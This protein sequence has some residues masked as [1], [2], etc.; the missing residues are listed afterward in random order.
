MSKADELSNNLREQE[1]KE[2]M[3][4]DGNPNGT[5]DYSLE[6][7][8][9]RGN[10]F[11]DY[12]PSI[13]FQNKYW[14]DYK[15]DIMNRYGG[16]K[17][18][19]TIKLSEIEAFEDAS[20][21]L[22][23]VL[24]A[25]GMNLQ[26][27]IKTNAFYYNKSGR[28]PLTEPPQV[29]KTYIFFTRPDLN[30]SKANIDSH[31]TFKWLW[32]REMG[33][34]IFSMLTGPD[35]R[36]YGDITGMSP[37]E[38]GDNDELMETNPLAAAVAVLKVPTKPLAG[39]MKKFYEKFSNT[40]SRISDFYDAKIAPIYK[41]P[42][43]KPEEAMRGLENDLIK[44]LASS[45]LDTEITAQ[46]RGNPP[47]GEEPLLENIAPEKSE[48]NG[49]LA[50]ELP[51][52]FNPWTRTYGNVRTDPVT[53]EDRKMLFTSPW[54]PL[55][56]N[57]CTSAPAGKDLMLN[58]FEYA[59]DYRGHKLNVATGS[60]S[61]NNSGEESYTFKDNRL[62]YVRWLF[63]VWTQY[64]WAVNEGRMIPRWENI[65]NRTLD[66]TCG[67]YKFVLD[68]DGQTILA[69]AQYT[70]CSPRSFPMNMIFHQDK[71]LD[72]ESFRNISI[73]FAYNIYEP[74]NPETFTAFNF[75]SETEWRRKRN[76]KEDLF[77]IENTEKVLKRKLT[78][79]DIWEELRTRADQYSGVSGQVPIRALPN[80]MDTGYFNH[81]NK[82]RSENRWDYDFND[83]YGGYPYIVDANKLIWISPIDALYKDPSAPASDPFYLNII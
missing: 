8:W 76:L 53:G 52:F 61:L 79:K 36:V 66:Y 22:G 29:G 11:A 3:K 19:M 57:N 49:Y 41:N 12:D 23:D 59:E 5:S 56:S 4:R 73:N 20:A 34:E 63:Y 82:W 75:L 6:T 16:N 1:D 47:E 10:S 48:K 65:V 15:T 74:F 21:M 43:E 80:R 68:K 33:R 18:N 70:G 78:K 39:M 72:S 35:R 44:D 67:I 13:R 24:S 54:I 2:K 37:A 7:E 26:D 50:K 64:I 60:N 17:D 28:D 46:I 45:G 77:K 51:K 40:I 31:P 55:L 14:E 32:S 30:L 42:G 38:L 83:H 62:G 27:P 58:S 69:W 25:G 81:Y 71:D 9:A